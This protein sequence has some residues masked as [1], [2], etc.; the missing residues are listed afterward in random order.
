MEINTQTSAQKEQYRG[1]NYFLLKD[2]YGTWAVYM[3]G[4]DQP[5]LTAMPLSGAIAWI[6]AKL[7]DPH[8][9]AVAAPLNNEPHMRFWAA[10]NDFLVHRAGLPEIPYSDA[11]E[12]WERTTREAAERARAVAYAKEYNL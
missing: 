6:D 4:E 10:I 12:L 9:W 7:A 5:I 2:R 1:S 11:R 3:T 8:R